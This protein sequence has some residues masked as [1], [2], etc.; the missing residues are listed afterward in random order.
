METTSTSLTQFSI[1]AI[2]TKKT[3]QLRSE[4]IGPHAFG[5]GGIPSPLNLSPINLSRSVARDSSVERDLHRYNHRDSDEISSDLDEDVDV[6][7]DY[8]DEDDIHMSDD[9]NIDSCSAG[10]SSL[11]PSSPSS[12]LAEEGVNSHLGDRSRGSSSDD[13]PARHTK[14]M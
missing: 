3:D 13:S 8:D 9:I 6:V 11:P 10:N 1:D 5:S 14:G 7:T 2:L 12:G 4:R